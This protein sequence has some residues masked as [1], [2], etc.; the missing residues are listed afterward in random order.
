MYALYL[1]FID[2]CGSLSPSMAQ[3]KGCACERI[4]PE[5]TV[6]LQGLHC[7]GVPP[8]TKSRMDGQHEVWRTHDATSALQGVGSRHELS[9]PVRLTQ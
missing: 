4:S 6:A 9:L 8:P 3:N 2:S 7:L 1:L 5:L